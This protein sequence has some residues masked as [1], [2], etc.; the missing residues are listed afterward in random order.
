ML[1]SVQRL[2]VAIGNKVIL[3]NVSISVDRGEIVAIMGP[4]GSGKTTLAYAIMGH[5]RYRIIKGRVILDGDDITF[6]PPYERARRGVFLAFQ[7]PPEIHGVKLK[8]LLDFISKNKDYMNM[9]KYLGFSEEFLHRDLNV[10]FSGGEKKRLEV[11]QMLLMKPKIAILDEPDSGVDI[12]SIRL[13]A[14]AI[15]KLAEEK[16]GVLLITHYTKLA[17]YLVPSRVYVMFNGR[18]VAS[19]DVELMNKIDSCG[20]QCIDIGKCLLEEGC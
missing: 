16:S 19:G 17:R 8:Y 15:K 14:K 1:F 6:L 13:I 10:G 11:L 18:I 12:D 4:N 3:S 20:Y 9:F 7:H 5:P 2:T